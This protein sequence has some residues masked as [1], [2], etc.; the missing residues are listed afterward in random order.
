MRKRGAP[1]PDYLHCYCEP[2]Q[3]PPVRRA[4]LSIL[5][6]LTTATFTVLD[7]S[8]FL[9]AGKSWQKSFSLRQKSKSIVELDSYAGGNFDV[10]VVI[11]MW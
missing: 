9:A 5:C 2:P 10:T 11:R 7:L 8:I 4:L 1:Q 3:P 6:I